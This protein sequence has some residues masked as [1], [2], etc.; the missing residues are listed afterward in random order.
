MPHRLIGLTVAALLGLVAALMPLGDWWIIDNG[1]LPI[2]GGLAAAFGSTVAGF[3]VAPRLE[4]DRQRRGLVA[5]R[6][7]LIAV[8][9]AIPLVA[10]D[11]A[12]VAGR[13]LDEPWPVTF[14]PI[15]G[16]ILGTAFYT[17]DL[18]IVAFPVA[19]LWTALASGASKLLAT[20]RR[21]T[22]SDAE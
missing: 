5:I 7:A 13:P 18:L 12:V 8:I 16:T 2:P 10:V 19:G 21:V 15:L 9:A 11:A 14:G 17:P 22:Y 20:P 1:F 3:I 4:S 6:F